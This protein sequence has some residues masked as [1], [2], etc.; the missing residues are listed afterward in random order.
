MQKRSSNH[1]SNR[2]LHE[3]VRSCEIKEFL[4]IVAAIERRY[5][6]LKINDILSTIERIKDE[7]SQSVLA[8]AALG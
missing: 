5:C 6:K 2:G 3:H 1:S 7:Y 4:L 8:I